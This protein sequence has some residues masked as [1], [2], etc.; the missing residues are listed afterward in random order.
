MG[1]GFLC[2]D[3]G[4]VDEELRRKI[5]GAVDDEIVILDEVEDVVARDEGMVSNHLHVR[6]HRFHGFLRGLYLGFT[7]ILRGVYYLALQIRKVNHI[8]IYNADGA[9]TCGGKVHGH[10]SAKA[11]RTN[12]ENLRVQELFLALGSHLF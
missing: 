4:V 2:H 10:R 7:H 3:A 8:G 9:H 12:H 1:E 6:V 5:V 11:S